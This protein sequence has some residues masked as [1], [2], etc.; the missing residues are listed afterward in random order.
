[1]EGEVKSSRK[2]VGFLD[3]PPELRIEIYRYCLVSEHPIEFLPWCPVSSLW[4]CTSRSR[5]L[6]LVSK[7]IGSEASEVLY[8][9]NVFLVHMHGEAGHQLSKRITES[10]RLKIRKLQTLLG[11]DEAFRKYPLNPV[12]WSPVLGNLRKLSIVAP[13]PM[14]DF[15]NKET[16]DDWI[17]WLRDFLQYIISLVPSSCII[18]VD[19]T[20][21][22]KTGILMREYLPNNHRK[23]QT[24]TGDYYFGRNDFAWE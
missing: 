12:I 6:L 13:K 1:M 7:T 3:L 19:N 17:G 9:E 8:G 18:E 24:L 23:V 20:E 4:R 14:L 15:R 22:A 5:S 16:K 11:T 2:P 10:N 21:K